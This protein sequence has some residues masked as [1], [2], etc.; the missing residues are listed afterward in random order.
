ML[1]VVEKHIVSQSYISKDYE[2]IGNM[3]GLNAK[4][5]KGI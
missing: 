3:P 1:D 2:V 4:G 5:S